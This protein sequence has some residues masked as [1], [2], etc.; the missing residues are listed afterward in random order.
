VLLALATLGLA[1]ASCA[2]WDGHFSI[3]GYSTR[4]NYDLSIHTVRVPIFQ[5]R[6][7][8]TTTPV[9][10]MEMD[11]TRAIIREIEDKTPYKVVQCNADTELSG[12]ILSFFK[13]PLSY[14][15]MFYARE[16]ETTLTV[17]LT[18]RDLRTGKVL[19]KPARRPYEP[20]PAEQRV[21]ILPDSLSPGAARPL[22][23]PSA[24]TLP[25]EGVAASTATPDNPDPLAIDPRLKPIIQPIQI[26]SVAHYRPEVGES[27]TTA[28][29]RNIDRMA[30]QIVSIMEKGW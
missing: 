16:I 25:G 3:L 26:R 2:S 12:S 7:F 11:L 14:N 27:I 29:Q 13:A 6:T 5:N 28:Q 1:L 4:P 8:W 9:P 22:V 17:E 30:V 20:L 15:Q 10:G 21:P 18:W 23:M 19:S 24:P